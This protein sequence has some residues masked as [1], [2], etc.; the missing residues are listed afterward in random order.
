MTTDELLAAQKVRD[1]DREARALFRN[2]V[3]HTRREPERD[4]RNQPPIDPPL[5]LPLAKEFRQTM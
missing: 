2:H 4:P 1:L 3:E 5:P